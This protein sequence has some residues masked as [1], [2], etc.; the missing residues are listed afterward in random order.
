MKLFVMPDEQ[1]I[2]TLVRTDHPDDQGQLID[3]SDA[4][5]ED[6]RRVEKEFVAWQRKLVERCGS[7]DDPIGGQIVTF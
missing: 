4:E 1:Q 3:I 5:L 7:Q 2:L 6:I